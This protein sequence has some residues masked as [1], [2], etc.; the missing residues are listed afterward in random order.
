MRNNDED[1]IQA[2]IVKW[3]QEKGI[4]F[5][6]VINQA[7][8]RSAIQQMQMITLGLKSGVSD[9]VLILSDQTIYCEVKAENGKQSDKQVQF[10]NR[11]EKLGHKYIVVKSV[12]DLAHFFRDNNL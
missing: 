3:L 1:K 2:H 7:A 9:L 4:E 5:F 11:V 12:E 8:G 6:A 10:Q